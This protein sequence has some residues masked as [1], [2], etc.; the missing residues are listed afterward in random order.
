MNREQ[1]EVYQHTEKGFKAQFSFESWRVGLLRADTRFTDICYLERHC[2]TDEA[3]AL[4]SGKAA[5]I[6]KSSDGREAFTRMLPEKVYN[7]PKG[8][9]HNILV[10]DDA[11]VIIIENCET[12]PHNSEY[13][14]FSMTR[15]PEALLKE[16]RG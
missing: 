2:L 12:G 7:I 11:T 16:I 5:L 13:E 10:S 15:F 4:L 6:T 1:P 3:F 8:L 14:D 9:L